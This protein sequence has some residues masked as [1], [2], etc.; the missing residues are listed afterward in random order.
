[1]GWYRTVKK[2]NRLVSAALRM[3]ADF[4]SLLEG[5]EIVWAGNFYRTIDNI[6]GKPSIQSLTRI[7]PQFHTQLN[8]YERLTQDP[9]TYSYTEEYGDISHLLNA[10]QG[11]IDY[12][13]ES[14]SDKTVHP[15]IYELWALLVRGQKV[16]HMMY[17]DAYDSSWSYGNADSYSSGSSLDMCVKNTIEAKRKNLR[18]IETMGPDFLIQLALDGLEYSPNFIFQLIKELHDQ[19]NPQAIQQIK[20]LAKKYPWVENLWEINKNAMTV[21]P[22]DLWVNETVLI[23][24]QIRDESDEKTYL[25]RMYADVWGPFF[26]E[27]GAARPELIFDTVKPLLDLGAAKM[28]NAPKPEEDKHNYHP[29]FINGNVMLGS[30][31]DTYVR[32][33]KVK[34]PGALIALFDKLKALKQDDPVRKYMMPMATKGVVEVGTTFLPSYFSRVGS[35]EKAKEFFDALEIK[36]AD[37]AEELKN[38]T[39]DD[40]HNVIPRISL[41]L[42][43][44]KD[45]LPLLLKLISEGRIDWEFINSPPRLLAP[46]LRDASQ[47]YPD[48]Y[49]QLTQALKDQLEER[50]KKEAEARQNKNDKNLVAQVD[51]VTMSIFLDHCIKN[52]II[53]KKTALED[54]A[55]MHRLTKIG[56]D[57][58]LEEEEIEKYAHWLQV[59]EV[60]D[61]FDFTEL[62]KDLRWKDKDYQVKRLLSEWDT[63]A[64]IFISQSQTH[65]GINA[66]VIIMNGYQSN[67]SLQSLLK[68]MGMPSSYNILQNATLAHEIAHSMHYLGTSFREE[69]NIASLPKGD[70]DE[71]LNY[72]TDP[73]E[74]MARIYGDVPY[75]RETFTDGV[76]GSFESIPHLLKDADLE[77]G[78]SFMLSNPAGMS[79]GIMPPHEIIE[80][81]K[82]GRYP[83]QQLSNVLQ[84][85]ITRQRK[86]WREVNELMAQEARKQ[87]K[88]KVYRQMSQVLQRKKELQRIESI[89]WERY[90]DNADYP[91]MVEGI[92]EDYKKIEAETFTL[93]QELEAIDSGVRDIELSIPYIA[94][95][96]LRGHYRRKVND[97]NADGSRDITDK[98]MQDILDIYTNF[99]QENPMGGNLYGVIGGAP[100][101]FPKNERMGPIFDPQGNLVKHPNDPKNYSP[102]KPER[103]D[104]I[105]LLEDMELAMEDRKAC[106][107]ALRILHG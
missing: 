93:R 33:S 65:D 57:M 75:M 45:L 73:R 8:K 89:Y 46:V 55:M 30:V 44:E 80:R 69:P 79:M 39:P 47:K 17:G 97:L 90:R 86:K 95:S 6:D 28:A 5:S 7:L 53:Q 25:R 100:G 40:P 94:E 14:L 26:A 31:A 21:H 91:R 98:E 107:L 78:F 83:N 71:T 62:M 20:T 58:G 16:R 37:I 102:L 18:T 41:G 74:L 48:L 13:I 87:A 9:H 4:Y 24:R 23:G 34:E 32:L 42:V 81:Y 99:S 43:S 106:R 36:H 104:D 29:D 60:V 85:K 84:K 67:S 52:K 51:Y 11:W 15:L 77:D 105:S 2:A 1:M 22:S 50:N 70:T 19:N 12:Y 82:E 56:K 88:A 27:F 35:P 54:S 103:N 68:N 49:Q 92:K 38:T 3:A 10:T 72:L 96:L 76:H 63:F 101:V 61:P 64:G 59:Y 66:P